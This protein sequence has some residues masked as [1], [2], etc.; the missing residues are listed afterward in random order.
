MIFMLSCHE[1]PSEKPSVLPQR[2]KTIIAIFAHSDD[3]AIVSPILSK[4]ADEGVNVYLVLATDGSQG[5]QPHVNIPA[6]DSLATVRAKEALCTTKTLGINPPILLGHEDSNMASPLNVISLA[7]KIDSLFTKLKPDVVITWGPDGGYGNVDHRIVSSVVTEVF[8]KSE[9]SLSK[10]LFYPGISQ[11][12]INSLPPLKTPSGNWFKHN[13]HTTQK[14]F[15][16]YRIPYTLENF[17][18]GREALGCCKSQTT[19]DVMD[20]VF[21]IFE[22]SKGVVY[23]RPWFGSD[24]IKDDVFE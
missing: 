7:K 17:K 13:I 3:E 10:K 20:E 6:G 12:M 16:T 8:Q 19:L 23:L 21:K 15:L 5:V 22:Q 18:I 9:L 1:N 24:T 11:E 4:Y 14:K 2:N